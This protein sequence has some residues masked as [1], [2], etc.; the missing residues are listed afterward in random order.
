MSLITTLH[1]RGLTFLIIEHV[2][3]SLLELTKRVLVLHE[4]RLI[5]EGTPE[6]VKRDKIVIEAYFGE[7]SEV[8]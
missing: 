5:K 3:R 2:V 8:A 1:D 4:G 6:E 7:E